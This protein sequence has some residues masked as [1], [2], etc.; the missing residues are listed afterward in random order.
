MKPLLQSAQATTDRLAAPTQKQDHPNHVF[1][2]V[3]S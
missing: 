3:Y 2:C 1:D